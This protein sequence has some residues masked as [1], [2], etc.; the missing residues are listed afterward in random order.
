MNSFYTGQKVVCINPK[1]VWHAYDDDGRV[2]HIYEGPK[3]DEICLIRGIDATGRG[4][5][6][7]GHFT[8]ARYQGGWTEVG[9]HYRGFRPLVEHKTDIS[10]FTA[11][12]VPQ[13]N[14]ASTSYLSRR[15]SYPSTSTTG[16]PGSSCLVQYLTITVSGPKH[17][18]SP[19]DAWVRL[20]ID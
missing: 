6:I 4:L 14:V 10:V 18:G 19:G 12:L 3:R 8:H 11:M 17:P 2:K 5:L 7:A 20:S 15:S 9:Y 1:N 16:T 13:H